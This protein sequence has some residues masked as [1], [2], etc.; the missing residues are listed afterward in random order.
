M[1]PECL[2]NWNEKSTRPE[3]KNAF[4]TNETGEPAVHGKR[5]SFT[6]LVYR[7]QERP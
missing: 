4:I 1:N 2:V 5:V 3:W 6:F 7:F